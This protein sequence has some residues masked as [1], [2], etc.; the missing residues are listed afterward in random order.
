MAGEGASAAAL[1]FDSE[2]E[3][4]SGGLCHGRSL[5]SSLARGA[6]AFA[7]YRSGGGGRFVARSAEPDKPNKGEG[8]E[9]AAEATEAVFMK[10]A[11]RGGE[12]E[13]E[14]VGEEEEGASLS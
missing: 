2:R 12:G 1:I 3:R 7:R 14:R 13:G 4:S 9:A 6:L 11:A 5:L 8:N 10:Q